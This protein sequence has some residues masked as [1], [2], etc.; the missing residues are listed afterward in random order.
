[1]GPK[2]ILSPEFRLYDAKGAL[3]KKWFIEWKE[4]GKRRKK[5]GDINSGGTPKERYALAKKLLAELKREKKRRT[6]KTEIALLKAVDDLSAGW[7]DKTCMDYKSKYSTLLEFLA[8]R[9]ISVELVDSFFVHLRKTR[10]GTTVNKYRSMLKMLFT[11]AGV[12]Y[13]FDDI[14]TAKAIKTPKR[15]FQSHQMKRLGTAIRDKDSE[16]WLFIQ[17]MYYCFIRPGELRRLKVSDIEFDDMLV[18]VRGAISKN[19]KTKGVVI[20]DQFLPEIETL[21]HRDPNEYIFSGIRQEM[22][23]KNT[24]Y[25]RFKSYLEEFGFGSDYS[26]YSIRHTGAVAAVKAGASLKELQLQFRHHSADQTDQYLRQLGIQD[27]V[28]LRKIHP[29]ILDIRGKRPA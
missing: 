17:F 8:G 15:Y 2:I 13:M 10:H 4:G 23:G 27:I 18:Y 28:T 26:L 16:L 3:D 5:Y 11:R 29:N 12:D 24:M 19:S 7:S 14:V 25:E 20:P 21:I 1:M 6:T 9:E 22:I